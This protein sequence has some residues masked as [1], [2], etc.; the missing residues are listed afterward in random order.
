MF[1]E[2]KP[3]LSETSPFLSFCLPLLDSAVVA[4]ML[5]PIVMLYIGDWSERY[6]EL[7]FLAFFLSLVVFHYTDIY[8][9]WRG[10]SLI[11]EFRS[12]SAGWLAMVCTV[13]FLLFI[14]KVAERY[15]RFVL[16]VWFTATPLVLFALHAGARKSLRYIRAKGRNQKTAAIAGAGDLGVSLAR[17]IET[18]PWAGIRVIGFF[19]DKKTSEQVKEEHKTNKPVLG[20]ISDLPGYLETHHLDFVYI[21]LPMR[22]E[23]KIQEILKKCRTLGAKIYLVPDL[24]SFAFFNTRVQQLGNMLLLDFNPDCSTKRLFDVVFSLGVILLTLPL[25]LVIA[26]LIRITSKGPVFYKHR[27]ITAAGR[28]FFCLKFRTMHVDADKRLREILENDPEAREE[29]E[30]TFKLKNDPRVTWIGNFLRKTSLDELPQFINVLKGEMSVV[31]ARPIVYQELTDYYKENGGIYCSIKPGITG[32][33]QISKRNDMEDY[34]ERVALDTWYALNRNFW[35][36]LK[37]IGMTVVSMIS[38]KGAY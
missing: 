17:Y 7:A 30:K 5:Y 32:P 20:A 1:S 9:P 33:W 6:G 8:R 38:G 35:M 26:V 24:N 36:D 27:R 4:L 11:K 29:W 10:Q 21:A 25:T 19:D 37:I 22:A 18:I 23:K 14:L 16:L 2:L 15:S 13:L 3:S 31:G 12:I 28:E 34:Q